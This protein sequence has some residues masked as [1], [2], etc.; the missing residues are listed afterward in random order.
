MA[1]LPAPAKRAA[2]RAGP[3]RAFDQGLRE[4]T[5]T[6]GD[7]TTF[8]AVAHRDRREVGGPAPLNS[9]GL[10]AMLPAGSR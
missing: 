10:T 4:S 9:D 7:T 2:D 3:V 8:S 6:A 5:P 1:W